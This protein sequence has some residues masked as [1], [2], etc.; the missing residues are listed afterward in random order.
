[1]T[2]NAPHWCQQILKMDFAVQLVSFKTNRGTAFLHNDCKLALL[3]NHLVFT[4]QRA[5]HSSQPHPGDGLS[6]G[7]PLTCKWLLSL[8]LSGRGDSTECQRS[9][10]PVPSPQSHV[11]LC[12]LVPMGSKS[13]SFS[14]EHHH[15]GVA[16]QASTEYC[17]QRLHA[18]ANKPSW[19]QQQHLFSLT[20]QNLSTCKQ[21][22]G[23]H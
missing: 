12:S 16:L 18:R 5:I 7:L 3:Q 17:Y 13:A 22:G 20:M 6:P 8:M 21:P 9:C 11:S 2:R 4:S 19:Q 23:A 15:W 1:M 14:L 10:I